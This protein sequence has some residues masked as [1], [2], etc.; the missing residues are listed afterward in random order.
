MSVATDISGP[1]QHQTHILPNFSET[2][3]GKG[4]F[5]PNIWNK[6]GENI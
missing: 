2:I 1:R 4:I 6:A 3:E 5:S